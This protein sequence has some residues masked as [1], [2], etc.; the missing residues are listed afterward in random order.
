MKARAASSIG[1]DAGGIVHRAVVDLVALELLVDA[2]MIEMRHQQHIFVG[3]RRIGAGEHGEH[4]RAGR[5]L[6][7]AL[8]LDLERLLQRKALRLHAFFAAVGEEG[9]ERRLRSREQRL[10]RLRIE[11][12]R[13][14]EA[15]GLG[16]GAAVRANPSH[17]GMV[18]VPGKHG[19]GPAVLLGGRADGDNADGATLLGHSG[20]LAAE[21]SA[22]L[23]R[24]PFRKAAQH[25]DHL[26]L[27]VE[28]G[29]IAEAL[30]RRIQAVADEHDR[31]LDRLVGLARACAGDELLAVLERAA[32]DG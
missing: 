5:A 3:Q 28:A 19:P 11:R 26:A 2:D 23:A 17:A 14:A 25:R 7:D 27:D 22:D 31:C 21:V 10:G 6:G 13:E 29:I 15:G 20:L 4:V 9:G 24:R 30:A 18:D 12:C 32:A 16:M 1:G 8:P